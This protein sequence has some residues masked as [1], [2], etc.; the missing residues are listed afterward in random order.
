MGLY[1]V[2]ETQ[3]QIVLGCGHDVTFEIA[4][5][6]VR[7]ESVYFPVCPTCRRAY[8]IVRCVVHAK[9]AGPEILERDVAIHTLHKR[10]CDRGL[11][12]AGTTVDGGGID[13]HPLAREDAVV[14]ALSAHR[15]RRE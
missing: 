7:E 8:G 15:V 13:V 6:R 14:E 10:V 5:C 2:S 1:R 4:D 3:A 12:L 9:E 11:H